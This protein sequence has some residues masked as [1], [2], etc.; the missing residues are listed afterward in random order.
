MAIDKPAEVTSMDD[1][2]LNV[3]NE[4]I[5]AICSKAAGVSHTSTV[6]TVNSVPEGHLVIYDNGSGTKRLYVVTG[7]KNLGYITLT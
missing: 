5:G 3:L 6:P 4:I 2:Q 7:K 1:S